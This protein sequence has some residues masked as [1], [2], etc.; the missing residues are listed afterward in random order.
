[1]KIYVTVLSI[2]FSQQLIAKDNQAD[3]I[4]GFWLT[5]SETAVIKIYKEIEKDDE[6]TETEY[7]GKIVWIK[8][9]HTGKVP[10]KFDKENPK[11]ELRKRS[12]LG[13]QNLD[14]FE[15]DGSEWT[16]GEIYDPKTG[17]TYSAKM[18]L[19]NKNELHLRGYVGIP[20]F[21]RTSV[22]KRQK[23][24]IPDQYKKN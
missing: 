10:D 16:G 21:G 20:L 8:D 14:D 13:L 11:K 5:K 1:M 24:V 2:L 22:W 17:K 9:I 3:D 6:E 4:L 18:R 19:E 12:L 23:G 15:F 7:R